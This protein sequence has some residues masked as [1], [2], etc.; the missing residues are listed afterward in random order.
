MNTLLVKLSS[1]DD[2]EQSCAATKTL[3]RLT[4][5]QSLNCSGDG[6]KIPLTLNMPAFYIKM[7]HVASPNFIGSTAVAFEI[8]SVRS[9]LTDSTLPPEL[10]IYS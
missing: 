5:Q 10:S 6:S 4:F 2:D 7:S 8:G 1:T 3:K 9:A